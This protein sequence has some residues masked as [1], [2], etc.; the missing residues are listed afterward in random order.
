MEYFLYAALVCA[1]WHWSIVSLTCFKFCYFI[2]ATG[3][4]QFNY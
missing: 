1:T 2:A 3:C 4:M